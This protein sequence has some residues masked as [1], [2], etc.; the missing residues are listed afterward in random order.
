MKQFG[1]NM[2]GFTL[3]ELMIVVAIIG[4]L[5]SIAIPN[6]LDL[7]DKALWGTARAN[8]DVIRSS[9]ASYAASSPNSR[10]PAGPMDF[11]QFRAALPH[12]SLP[13]T[14]DLSKFQSSSFLYSSAADGTGFSV[15]AN[16]ANRAYDL[17][18][19]S[20]SGITPNSY[21]DYIR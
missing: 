13:V 4:I 6:F 20:P 3:I 19:A 18:T 10:Y 1:K 17:M 2:R 21:D 12:A 11:D 14:E 9:L 7:K 16:A 5:A 8:L 15:S